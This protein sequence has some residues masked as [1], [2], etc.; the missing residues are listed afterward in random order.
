M[1]T[2]LPEER[3]REQLSVLMIDIDH[4]KNFND[5]YGH[6]AGDEALRVF[7]R[8]VKAS[9]RASDFAARYGARNSLSRCATPISTEP[10]WSPRN[11]GQP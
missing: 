1:A 3:D 8:V 2:T 9:I 4:F 11:F 7:G 5:T 6:P 10:P